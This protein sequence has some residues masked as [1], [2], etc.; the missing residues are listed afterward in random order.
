MATE[1]LVRNTIGLTGLAALGASMLGGGLAWCLPMTWTTVA[2]T[3]AVSAREPGAALLTWPVQPAGTTAATVAAIVLGAGGT[4]V[5]A[6]IG[7]PAT[8]TVVG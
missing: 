1:L 2:V 3:V 4:V 8:R 5:Y 6:M 7:P